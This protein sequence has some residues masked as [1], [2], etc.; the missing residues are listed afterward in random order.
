[1]LYLIRDYLIKRQ[2]WVVVRDI[3]FEF[4]FYQ[5]DFL[6]LV[7][8]GLKME[9]IIIITSWIYFKNFIKEFLTEEIIYYYNSAHFGCGALTYNWDIHRSSVS[10]P[11]WTKL[12]TYRCRIWNYCKTGVHYV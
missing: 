8:R 11:I 10:E 7:F 4:A 12:Q 6:E 9:V 3:N 2:N 1:M 5:F